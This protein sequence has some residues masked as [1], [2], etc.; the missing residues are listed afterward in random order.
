MSGI[1]KRAVAPLALFFSKP[2]VGRKEV[3]SVYRFRGVTSTDWT[4]RWGEITLP[5]AMHRITSLCFFFIMGW[6]WPWRSVR[7]E[8]SI[9]PDT[10]SSDPFPDAHEEPPACSWWLSLRTR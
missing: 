9:R 10:E 4:M 5:G 6:I 7:C 8:K 3:R 1:R 2:L